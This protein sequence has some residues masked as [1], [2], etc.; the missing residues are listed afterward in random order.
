MRKKYFHLIAIILTISVLACKKSDDGFQ[1]AEVVDS[2]DI[3]NEGCG[4]LLRFDDGRE[5]KPYQLLSAYQHNGM[6]VKVK[7]H[8][9]QVQDTC[10][11]S[12]PYSYYQLIIIDDI[13][14]RPQ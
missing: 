5:E 4:Y 6:K 8:D 12:K 2:G 13:K 9:S 14:N 3:T 11:S 1:N 7:Y 10:G